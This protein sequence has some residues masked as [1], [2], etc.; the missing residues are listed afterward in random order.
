MPAGRLAPPSDATQFVRVPIERGA[1]GLSVYVERRVLE[2]L[3][4][5]AG[6]LFFVMDL[7]RRYKLHLGRPASELLKGNR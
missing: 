5:D 6:E 2:Q 1:G 7:T 4:P 3:P